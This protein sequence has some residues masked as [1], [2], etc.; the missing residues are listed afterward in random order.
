MEKT[1]PLVRRTGFARKP[2]S[3][4]YYSIPTGYQKTVVCPLLLCGDTPRH[5]TVPWGKVKA[6]ETPVT[7][8]AGVF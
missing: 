5:F 8:V 3:V 7:S 4:P 6:I 2:W 1:L